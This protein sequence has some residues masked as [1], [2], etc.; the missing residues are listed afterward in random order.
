VHD[1]V[2]GFNMEQNLVTVKLTPGYSFSKVVFYISTESNDPL[3]ATLEES[4]LT[5]A[6]EGANQDLPDHFIGQGNERLA[7]LI[8]GPT[9]AD[10]PFRQGIES[11]I[12]DGRSPLNI[13]GGVPTI[14]LGLQPAV[15]RA[16]HPVVARRG[17]E[18]LP[19]PHHRPAAALRPRGQGRA[20][21]VRRRADQ[22][23][24][25]HHQLPG[26]VRASSEA[27]VPCP[28]CGA[29]HAVAGRSRSVCHV[30]RTALASITTP[31]SSAAIGSAIW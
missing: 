27:R 9:G 16:A 1:K 4:T 30:S 11:A 14:N 3:A 28:S 21:G 25:H 22:A 2:V 7:I 26:R 10:H 18:G 19:H 6:L 23:Q 5:P 24:R 8:N 13:F 29:G 12:R 17:G 20:R 31:I 15:G